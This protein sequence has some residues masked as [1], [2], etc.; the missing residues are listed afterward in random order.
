MFTETLWNKAQKM[1][2]PC[3]YTLKKYTLIKYTLEIEIWK[4]L[5]IA[6]GKHHIWQSIVYGRSVNG[7]EIPIQ[8][9]SGGGS[10]GALS[11]LFF[12]VFPLWSSLKLQIA[13]CAM[14]SFV[15][16]KSHTAICTV[17]TRWQ[18]TLKSKLLSS[19]SHKYIKYIWLWRSWHKYTW[20]SSHKYEDW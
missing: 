9:K 2:K 1:G 18:K 8:W 16:Q 15:E 11:P 4:L 12:T 7:P 3:M 13:T 19:S 14:T 20:R 5:I 10:N 6:F 17:K